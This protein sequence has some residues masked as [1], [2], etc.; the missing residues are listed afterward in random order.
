MAGLVAALALLGE[1]LTTCTSIL[2]TLSSLPSEKLCLIFELGGI[3]DDFRADL[4]ILRSHLQWYEDQLKIY[5]KDADGTVVEILKK[6]QS[7]LK[8]VESDVK[9]L[10]ENIDS[11]KCFLSRWWLYAKLYMAS[12][13]DKL[14]KK[15]KTV[16]EDLQAMPQLMKDKI[17]ST[18]LMQQSASSQPITTRMY[19]NGLY[20]PIQD[21]QNAVL[22]AI[23][24]PHDSSRIVLLWGGPGKGK[25]TLAKYVCMLYGKDGGRKNLFDYVLFVACGGSSKIDP[26]NKQYEILKRLSPASLD[27]SSESKKT[28][29]E[30]RTADFEVRTAESLHNFFLTSQKTLVV[31]DDVADK[32][33]ISEMWKASEGGTQVKYLVTSQYHNLCDSF[34]KHSVQID[35]QNPSEKEAQDILAS[36]V[37][38]KDQTIPDKLQGIAGKLIEATGRNPLA[39]A[40][41][42]SN[43]ANDRDKTNVRAWKDTYDA[44]CF[45]LD[46]EETQFVL[47]RTP[48]SPPRSLWAAMKICVDSL[49]SGDAKDILFLMYSCEAEVV[50]QEVLR[51]LH[52]ATKTSSGMFLNSIE[53]LRSRELMKGSANTIAPKLNF[54]DKDQTDQEESVSWSLLTTVKLY[55][56]QHMTGDEKMISLFGA[57]L[58]NDGMKAE[59][60]VKLK[61][62]SETQAM[63][64]EKIKVAIALRALYF[65]TDH[66]NIAVVEAAT[67]ACNMSD[68]HFDATIKD[69]IR[70]AIEPLIWLLDQPEDDD[71]SWTESDIQCVRQVF[72]KY[73]CEKELDD[74]NIC[75]LLKLE[76]YPAAQVATLTALGDLLHFEETPLLKHDHL[77]FLQPLVHILKMKQGVQSNLQLA[78]SKTL[79]GIAWNSSWNTKEGEVESIIMTMGPDLL[80]L[81]VNSIQDTLA[82]P[83]PL[84]AVLA[85]NAASTLAL[86][87]Y[88]SHSTRLWISNMDGAIAS[89][90]KAL[91]KHDNP[92]LQEKAAGALFNLAAEGDSI[93]LQILSADGALENLVKC[94]S[95]DHNPQLQEYAAW[96]LKNLAFA[97][98]TMEIPLRILDQDGALEGLVGALSK[99]QNPKL[100]QQAAAALCNLSSRSGESSKLQISRE[101]GAIASLVKALGKDDNPVMPQ[102]A[103][104]ALSNLAAGGDSIKLQILSADGALESL[105]KC[106]SKDDDPELQKNA[107]CALRNLAGAKDTTEIPLRIL[108][109]D[110]AL[111]GLVAALSKDQN[112]QLQQAAAA[113]LCNLSSCSGES[114]KLQI[115]RENAAIA[116]LVKALGKDDN[117]ILQ[118]HAAAAL[119]Y[120][121]AGGDSIKLQILSADGALESLVKCLSKDDDPELQKN[122]AWALR[123]LAGAKDTM[124]IPLRILGQ[125]GALEGLVGALSKDQN[126]KLQQAAAAALW[127]LS[128]YLGESSKLQISRENGA[129]ASLV[130][131]LGKDDNPILQQKAVGALSSLAAGGDSIKLQILSADGAL[132]SLVKC[133]S[134]DD[135]PEL[136][137]N[138]AWALRSLAGAKD[139]T[140]IPLRI[141]G[142]DGALKGLVAALSKD[143]NPQLQQAAAAALCNLSSRSGESSKLQISRENG[144]I[145]SLVK[146]LG[147]DDNPIL[148]QHAAGALLSLATGGDSIKLQILSADGAPESL[149]NC[150]WKDANPKLQENAAWALGYL[151]GGKETKEIA[152]RKLGEH[153]AREGLVAALSKDQNQQLQRAAAWALSKIP[154]EGVAVKLQRGFWAW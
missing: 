22:D 149:V 42:A 120:L 90:T 89:L 118:Q 109:Q 66:N 44:L 63:E 73:V 53:E 105:M 101:N 119:F 64:K 81:L 35:M 10:K 134:K 117:P 144:A 123:N 27:I 55:I 58:G 102:N 30:E 46:H 97:K 32:D 86:L 113:A 143:Q 9:T 121:A 8:E 146:V 18:V 84:S 151:A 4:G 82:S 129:I 36:L 43:F 152:F 28:D 136:Q 106:L 153:G 31:L 122:A 25:S 79:S 62:D 21:S 94:L 26:S 80:P 17:E 54:D 112:P 14:D 88:A 76:G 133:L 37:G 99:D 7:V 92:T 68:I 147:K 87:S 34:P 111:E 3:P 96:A 131:A 41:L 19:D 2:E 71:L 5:G 128:V 126:P 49:K 137:E 150:L 132:E 91:S 50:P 125:D 108:G 74:T 67:R 15:I 115:L 38:L 47:G 77:T 61:L 142:Q 6:A 130:K 75:N 148:Q 100:Q 52:A 124:E 107:A 145:A 13:S 65:K 138:A 135:N 98:D 154:A 23:E 60:S 45:I 78:A 116:S 95:K 57:L 39:L 12:F 51:L 11:N 40:C 56:D 69:R 127:N 140:K 70:K 59:S 72:L 114:S 139:R 103:A 29:V 16:K 83:T 33:F 110:G 85:Q 20:V 104:G 48:E 141:L 24:D 1:G 93:K